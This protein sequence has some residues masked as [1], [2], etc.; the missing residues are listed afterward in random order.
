M[1]FLIFFQE[2]RHPG[3]RHDGTIAEIGG[4]KVVRSKTLNPQHIPNT[5]GIILISGTLKS[6]VGY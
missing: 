1:A 6:T 4:D 5:N 3:Q 2:C